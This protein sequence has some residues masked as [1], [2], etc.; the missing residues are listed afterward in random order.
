MR[1]AVVRLLHVV[2]RTPGIKYYHVV[3]VEHLTARL[4]ADAP[5]SPNAITAGLTLL[6]LNSYFPQG[7]TVTGTQQLQRTLT[8]LSTDPAAAAVFYGNIAEHLPV[9]AV[10]QLMGMLSQCLESTIANEKTGHREE[11]PAENETK[12]KRRKTATN[13]QNNNPTLSTADTAF[14]SSLTEVID[15]LWGSIEGKIVKDLDCRR[16]LVKAFSGRLLTDALSFFEKKHRNVLTRLK[17]QN[18]SESV[19]SF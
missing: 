2:K 4:V 1:L 10:V 13:Q 16:S 6:M 19:P 5:N 17:G 3:P 9:R 14:I 8:F 7:E 15:V 12:Q 11:L 18:A